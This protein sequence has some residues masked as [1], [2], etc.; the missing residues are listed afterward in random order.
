MGSSEGGDLRLKLV[1]ELFQR[2]LLADGVFVVK[3]HWRPIAIS[4]DLFL[5]LL[6]HVGEHLNDLA[7]N[8]C[9]DRALAAAFEMKRRQC[10][11]WHARDRRC[12]GDRAPINGT[13]LAF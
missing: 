11:L 8:S 5:H 1:I 4:P 9:G 7:F 10:P 3:D 6:F 13:G 2:F 12:G